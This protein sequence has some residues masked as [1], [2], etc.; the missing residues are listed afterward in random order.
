MKRILTTLSQKWPS[1]FPSLEGIKGWVI[2]L[3]KIVTN[4]HEKNYSI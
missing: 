2:S 1:L 3:Q 4:Y